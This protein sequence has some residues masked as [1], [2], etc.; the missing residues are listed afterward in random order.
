LTEL[1]ST[2]NWSIGV[3]TEHM[4]NIYRESNPEIDGVLF[5]W[6]PGALDHFSIT[7]ILH[8]SLD[9][10]RQNRLSVICPEVHGF[11]VQRNHAAPNCYADT[12]RGL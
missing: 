12:K 5:L 3:K 8:H 6:S 9:F 10:S 11:K 1:I 2:F 4:T 7:S